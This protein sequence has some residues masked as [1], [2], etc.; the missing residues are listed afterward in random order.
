MKASARS[1]AF[2]REHGNIVSP[3][4]DWLNTFGY[5]LAPGDNY[6]LG[7]NN[8]VQ[9][10][11][12]CRRDYAGTG[13]CTGSV[14]RQWRSDYPTGA[15]VGGDF[16]LNVY[17][18]GGTLITVTKYDSVVPSQAISDALNSGD[19]PNVLPCPQPGSI[20]C[21]AY[22]Q[23]NQSTPYSS[24]GIMRIAFTPIDGISGTTVNITMPTAYNSG[25]SVRCGME[26]AS[27]RT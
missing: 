4:N 20:P 10:G 9:D 11:Y 5:T 27:R 6:F 14:S 17:R 23:P 15:D 16:A 13:W 22:Y 2:G 26:T 21:G 18:L 19:I 3:S 7:L 12:G 24:P 8:G 25:H 1:Q